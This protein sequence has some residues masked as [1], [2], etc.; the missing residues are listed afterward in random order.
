MQSVV[1]TMERLSA[2]WNDQIASKR[3]GLT[4][5]FASISRKWSPFGLSSR[6]T[7]GLAGAASSSPNYD[8]LQGFY[9]P[10]TP[11]ALMRKLAD[12]AFMLRDYRLAQGTYDLLKADFN[13]DKAWKYYAGANEMAAI[14]TLLSSEGTI[15]K[16]RTDSI[17]QLLETAWYTYT[18]RCNSSYHALRTLAIAVELLQIRSTPAA[19]DAA[20]WAAQVLDSRLVG[21]IGHALFTE[22]IVACS[23]AKNPIGS[24]DWG[25]RKRKAAFWS[26]LATD[27]WMGLGKLMQAERCLGQALVYY[28]LVDE[29][30]SKMLKFSGIK[31]FLDELRQSVNAAK[32]SSDVGSSEHEKLDID[33]NPNVDQETEQL[34]MQAQVDLDSRGEEEEPGLSSKIPLAIPVGPSGTDESSSRDPYA[35]VSSQRTSIGPDLRKYTARD[36]GFE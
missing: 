3:R 19:D 9:R 12:Y 14:S 32:I 6:N 33:G 4:G 11:E 13:Q 22:R 7:S 1:P 20:K 24:L 2:T 16:A 30:K 15:S 28:G 31:V 23:L 5:R 35:E 27:A 17:D 29:N 8:S 36:D 26:A 10:D 34:D 18:T 25:G 21:P